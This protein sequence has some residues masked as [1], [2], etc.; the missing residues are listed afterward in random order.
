VP[1]VKLVIEVD[2]SQHRKEDESQ[3]DKIRDT[4]L[5]ALGLTVMRFNSSEVLKETSV[6]ADVIYRR[7]ADFLNSEI[8]LNPPFSKGDL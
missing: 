4:A 1:K 2:G 3:K 5:V 8:S 6:V 7:I